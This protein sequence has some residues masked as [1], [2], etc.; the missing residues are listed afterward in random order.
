MILKVYVV[1][2]NLDLVQ[3][4]EVDFDTV[5]AMNL[6]FSRDPILFSGQIY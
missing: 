3:D 4:N 2:Q 1:S 6:I 5:Q